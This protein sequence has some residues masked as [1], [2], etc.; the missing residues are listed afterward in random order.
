MC[1]DHPPPTYDRRSVLGLAIGAV[2]AGVIVGP[3]ASRAS[4][5]GS[6]P[7]ATDPQPPAIRPR[8]D[9]A[10]GVPDA[11][12][13][14]VEAPGDVR[15]LL[16]HHTATA[17]GYDAASVPR[18]I[19]SM[20]GYH[21]GTKAWPDIAYNY[22]VDRFG[23]VWEGRTG[24]L[25]GPVIGD[26][27]GGNQGF[28]QLC[29]FIGDHSVEPPSPEATIA[30]AGLLATLSQR[31]A[32]PIDQGATA[33]FTSRGSNRWPPGAVVVCPTIEGHRAMSQTTCP[34]DAGYAAV[35][36]DLRGRALVL[37]TA[38][39]PEVQADPTT[40]ITTTT[41]PAE[42]APPSSAAPASSTAPPTTAP[43]TTTPLPTPPAGAGA[44]DDSTIPVAAVAGGVA[45]VTVAGALGV[46]RH[47][48]RRSVSEA[49]EAGA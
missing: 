40:T 43:T 26:A 28:S 27:T 44:S 46:A 9:W 29:C 25:A 34:G 35:T 45:A 17:N 6:P 38:W 1:D 48:R 5:A 32:V 47:R 39:D 20:H 21:T 16:V 10:T 4:A 23:T 2:V 30:M 33:E 11:T 18:M 31:Y 49:E 22:F 12:G 15:V 7:N 41:T 14:A 37:R 13:L 36:G 42:V 24:S 8:A 19:R 3:V